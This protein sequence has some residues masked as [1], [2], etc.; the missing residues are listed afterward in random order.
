MKLLVVGGVAGG[1]SAAARAAR[2]DSSVEIIVFERGQSISF[3]NCGL[4]YYIG[5][6]IKQRES[7]LVMTP[8]NFKGRTGIEVRTM[9][10]AIEINS[11]EKCIKVKNLQSGEVYTESYDKLLLATGSSPLIPPIPGADDPDVMTL[12]TMPDVDRIKGRVDA[13]VKS[14]VVIGGG[15][16]GLEVAENL[17]E[18][19]VDVTLVEMLPHIM[20]NMD[21]EMAHM[22]EDEFTEKGVKLQLSNGVTEINRIPEA[23]ERMQHL[24]VTLQDGTVIQTELIIMSVGRETKQ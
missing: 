23:D 22:L 17:I 11:D 1:A 4:P 18:R 2:L 13:G 8:E 20:S 9:Q 15:F 14:A 12:W 3:A 24:S 5:E 6:V 19:G 21:V 16:I 7:L 10:E